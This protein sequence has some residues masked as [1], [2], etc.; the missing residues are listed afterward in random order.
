M[1]LGIPLLF[2]GVGLI[3][4]AWMDAPLGQIITFKSINLSLFN[5]VRRLSV[6][7]WALA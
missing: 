1:R 4:L 2:L 3:N 6:F 5:S 7:F